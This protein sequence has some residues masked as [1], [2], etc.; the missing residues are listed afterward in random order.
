MRHKL[1]NSIEQAY[2]IS[3]GDGFERE[4]IRRLTV[5]TSKLSSLA[6][7]GRGEKPKK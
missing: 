7:I 3:G 1:D 2:H 4:F 5:P 6:F